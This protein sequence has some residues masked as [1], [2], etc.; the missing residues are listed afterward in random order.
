MHNSKASR[1]V[2][3][4]LSLIVLATHPPVSEEAPLVLMFPGTLAVL[5]C[6]DSGLPG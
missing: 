6:W 2:L 4:G 3:K 5:C 1:K